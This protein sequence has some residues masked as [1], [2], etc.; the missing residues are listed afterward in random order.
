M[1]NAHL[2]SAAP[3]LL[4]AANNTVDYYKRT[5]PETICLQDQL[6]P[7]DLG[8]NGLKHWGGGAACPLC[9]AR[10]AIA[11]ATSTVS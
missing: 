3:D 8:G 6:N 9:S 4:E 1:S 11:K 7:C 2:I 10:A 5:Q